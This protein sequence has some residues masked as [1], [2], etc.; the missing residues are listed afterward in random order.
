[1]EGRHR[2]ALPLLQECVRKVPDH[3]FYRYHLGMVAVLGSHV[4]CLTKRRRFSLTLCPIS[5][6]VHDE[7]RRQARRS[8]CTIL[9]RH[10]KLLRLI[11]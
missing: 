10:A 2:L 5:N 9:Q 4:S 1:M 11:M 3:P 7:T 6:T 8:V